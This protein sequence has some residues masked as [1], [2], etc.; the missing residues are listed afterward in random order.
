[1][2]D[3]LQFFEDRIRQKPAFPANPQPSWN[4]P[5][6]SSSVIP[7]FRSLVVMAGTVNPSAMR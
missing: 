4:S 7:F 3:P 2:T 5:L 6:S 1:M